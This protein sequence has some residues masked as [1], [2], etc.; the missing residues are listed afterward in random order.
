VADLIQHYEEEHLPH[1]APRSASD[2]KS[3]LHRYVAPH[4]GKH[5]V[6]EIEPRDVNKL[7]TM[8]AEGTVDPKRKDRGKPVR[9]NRTGEVLRKMFNLSIEWKMRKDNPAASFRRRLEQERERFLTQDE[10]V[11]LAAVLDADPDDRTVG[12]IRMAW[13]TS[14]G[15]TPDSRIWDD[16]LHGAEASVWADKAYVSAE[17]AEAFAGP[18]KFW[19]VMRKAAKGGKL[20]PDDEYINRLIAKVRARVEH[21]FRVLKRQFGYIKTRYRG[22][23]KNRAQLFSLFALGNLYLARRRLMA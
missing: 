4:W 20:H 7:L 23:A 10:I 1:L 8:I 13:I 2:Q 14:P 22:L 11:R 3:M 16:L 19:G 15:S 6:K 18:G 12:I 9:A 5:L 21:P 17:R